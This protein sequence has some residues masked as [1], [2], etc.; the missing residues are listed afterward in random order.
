[1]NYAIKETN[2]RMS[3]IVDGAWK[4]FLLGSIGTNLKSSDFIPVESIGS[5]T[6]VCDEGSIT[7]ISAQPIGTSM[8]KDQLHL[9]TRKPDSMSLGEAYKVITK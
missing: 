2:N 7:T 8:S 3:A 6:F 9:I 1:M 4:Q 5:T